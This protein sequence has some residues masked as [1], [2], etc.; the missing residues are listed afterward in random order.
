MSLSDAELL[1][2]LKTARDRIVAALAVG[3]QIVEWEVRGLRQRRKPSVELL[4]QI[5]KLI[6]RYESKSGSDRRAAVARPIR[7]Y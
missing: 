3:D 1:E 6:A 4:D 7:P 5:E 2:Q